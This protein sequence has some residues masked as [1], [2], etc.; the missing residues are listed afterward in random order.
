MSDTARAILDLA[1]WAPSGDNTQPWR[2]RIL[3]HDHLVV[4]GFDTRSHCVY[5]LD[6]HA[7]HIALGALLETLRIAATKFGLRAEARHRQDSSDDKPV[8]DVRLRKTAVTQDRLVD[9]I[10]ERCVQRRPLSSRRLR[11]E[12]KHALQSAVGSDFELRWYESWPDRLAVARLNFAN[13][14]IRL[15]LPEAYEVHRDVIEWGVEVSEDRIPAAA[16]GA[17]APSLAI[18]HWG[19]ASWKRVAFLNRYLGGTLGP[20]VE[21][22]LI[23]GLACAAHC[24]LIAQRI[25]Q[26]LEDY[27]QVGRALQRFWLTAT[28][29]GLQ[30]Q[31][32]YTPLVFARYAGE[33]RRFCT[34]TAALA[35]ADKIRTRLERLLG[36]DVAPRTAFLGRIGAGAPAKAR[37]L[38]L[39]LERLLVA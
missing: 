22:D 21:L 2:F 18:M 6:G 10:A 3:S 13:A 15:T 9:Y 5:D 31:P 34:S 26:H 38:R 1:R 35:Q 16:I 12:E 33:R 23:P 28:T 36:S 4:Y 25:P 11:P 39:P 27:L 24:A 14:K 29:L 37:S 20:R 30:F 19:M 17:S 8:F 7:S 32:E